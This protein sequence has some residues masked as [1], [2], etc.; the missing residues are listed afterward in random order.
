MMSESSTVSLST[1]DVATSET[2]TSA[3][4]SLSEVKSQS[5]TMVEHSINSKN[6]EESG[7]DLIYNIHNQEVM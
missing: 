4:A 2:S 7:D 1:S 6:E 5:E 3:L